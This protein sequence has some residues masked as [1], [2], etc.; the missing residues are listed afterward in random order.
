MSDPVHNETAEKAVLGSILLSEGRVIPDVTRWVT[1]EDFYTPSHAIIFACCTRLYAENQPV[2][3]ETVAIQLEREGNLVRVGA[4]PALANLLSSTPTAA[5]VEFYAKAVRE[6]SHLRALD[7][8]CTR[9]KELVSSGGV[10]YLDIVGEFE[11][12]LDGSALLVREQP[13]G[14]G[15]LFDE[16]VEWQD[17]PV[18]AVPT[19]WLR[20]NDVLSGGFHKGRLYIFSARPGCGKS[21]MGLNSTTQAAISGK[22][23]LV[24]SLE[25][26]KMEVMSRMLA[27][28]AKANYGQITRHSLDKENFNKIHAWRAEHPEFQSRIK[29]DDTTD[30]LEDMMAICRAQ[31]RFG[32]DYV[33][34]D[35]VQLMKVRGQFQSRYQELGE[36]SR[37]LKQMAKALDITVVLA[38]QSGRQQDDQKHVVQMGDLR[39]SGNLEAD[40]DVVVFLQR[41]GDESMPDMPLIKVTVA[42]NRTGQTTFFE[43]PEHFDQARIG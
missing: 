11:K 18:P 3:A 5:N 17:A 6:S 20:M 14:F 38:A 7:A 24:F 21:V 33:F 42:K 41:G 27:A 26:P 9:G 1:A 22:K 15:D 30:T 37:V 2:D 12:L 23:C 35:Y 43:L 28:G 32:L 39:E 31:K 16:W 29:I 25:M 19:P 10:E 34:I 40:A 36:I 13:E 4:G 8:L